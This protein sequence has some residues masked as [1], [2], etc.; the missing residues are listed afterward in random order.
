MQNMEIAR[1]LGEIGDLLNI[2]GDDPYRVRAY[3]N[4]VR[5]ISN[6]TRPLAEMIAQGEDLA[7]LPGI[8]HDIAGYIAELVDSGHLRRLEDLEKTLPSGLVELLRIPAVGPKRARLLHDALGIRSLSDLRQAVATGKVGELKG[9]GPRT[10][11]RIRAGIEAVHGAAER[12]RLSDAEQFVRPLIAHMQQLPGV[13]LVEAA[14]SYRRRAETVG[15]ID[16]L[17]ISGTPS[18]VIRSFVAYP[19]VARVDAAGRTRSTVILRGGLQVRPAC[20]APGVPWCRT[21]LLHRLESAQHRG[22]SARRAPW[23]PHQ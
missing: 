12:F 13:E 11:A 8:G 14:G 18:S 1:A 5:T 9:F 22:A 2:Q 7:Q 16:L 17:V 6:L 23:T 3:R 19:D 20:G 21:P 15:D 4:A 10:V